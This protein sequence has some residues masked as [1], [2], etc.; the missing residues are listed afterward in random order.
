MEEREFLACKFFSQQKDTWLNPPTTYVL[1]KVSGKK[2]TDIFC[3]RSSIFI[4]LPLKHPHYLVFWHFLTLFRTC[5]SLCMYTFRQ[6]FRFE[7][8][9]AT[10]GWNS[11]SAKTKETFLHVRSCQRMCFLRKYCG[12]CVDSSAW[13]MSYVQCCMDQVVLWRLLR[14][15]IYV[16][17]EIIRFCLQEFALVL[18][19]H[20]VKSCRSRT[21]AL[22]VSS[23]F[24]LLSTINCDGKRLRGL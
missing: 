22:C 2:R 1:R 10:S 5:S 13:R 18:I 20:I 3:L 15:E 14:L 19:W 9:D 12:L 7:Q 16:N 4:T 23:T 6:L 17:A 11:T 21:S 24:A 8:L